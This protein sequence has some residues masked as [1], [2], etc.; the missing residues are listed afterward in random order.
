MG[1]SLLIDR[2]VMKVMVGRCD[3]QL[4]IVGVW[5]SPCLQSFNYQRTDGKSMQKN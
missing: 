2:V 4:N 5:C 1:F 3:L